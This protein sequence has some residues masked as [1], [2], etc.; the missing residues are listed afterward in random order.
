MRFIVLS[1]IALLAL[2]APALAQSDRAVAD[3]LP[4]FAKNNCQQI[5]DPG[6]QLFCGDSALAGYLERNVGHFG[7]EF[8]KAG[9]SQA[10]DVR[11]V[12]AGQSAIRRPTL[13]SEC[14]RLSPLSNRLAISAVRSASA[15]LRSASAARAR[16]APAS[17]LV[18]AAATKNIAN[19]TQFSPSAIENRPSGGRWKKLNAA[20]LNT[21]VSRPNQR[22]QPL[23]T[24]KTASM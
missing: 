23:E 14:S 9:E 19:P 1:V 24:N 11:I 4:L 13:L 12:A 2:A 18:T 3:R 6:N 15:R 20:A 7:L 16:A 10:D 22:P 17:V 8:L 5:R 21:A